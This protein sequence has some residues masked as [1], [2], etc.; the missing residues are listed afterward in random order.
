MLAGSMRRGR[1]SSNTLRKYKEG[2]SEQKRDGPHKS[3]GT[4]YESTRKKMQKTRVLQN[5][6]A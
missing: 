6:V 5:T 4:A 3:R 2:V 1:H